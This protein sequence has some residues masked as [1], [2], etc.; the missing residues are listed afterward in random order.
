MARPRGGTILRPRKSQV[1]PGVI[2]I[3]PCQLRNR[4]DSTVVVDRIDLNAERRV[5]DCRGRGERRSGPHERVQDCPFTQRQQRPDEDAKQALW[6]ERR[7]VGDCFFRLWGPPTRDHVGQ[8]PVTREHPQPTGPPL[9]QVLSHGLFGDRLSE[10]EPRLVVPARG[11][12][13]GRKILLGIFR[14]VPTP[15]AVIQPNNGRPQFVAGANHPLLHVHLQGRV[16]GDE[17]VTARNER[18][19]Q[20]LA[21]PLKKPCDVVLLR[22]GQHR[23]A[24]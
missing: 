3:K 12:A 22:L 10:Q 17:D 14:P 4:S 19:E 20:C 7:V 8:W 16:R 24:R 5:T 1:I 23:E 15:E 21:P 18:A 13:H 11:H 9:P 6:L 2:G